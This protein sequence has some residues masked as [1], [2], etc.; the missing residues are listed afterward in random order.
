MLWSAPTRS[1][2]VVLETEGKAAIEAFAE[3]HDI[4]FERCGKLVVALDETELERLAAVRERALA[5]GVP[6]LEEVG[7]ERIRELEPR[8]AVGR[9]PRTA[10]D[11]PRPYRRSRI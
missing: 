8:G 1:L 6:G 10:Y 5:N 3:T 11:S 4:P 2:D 7:P 9:G